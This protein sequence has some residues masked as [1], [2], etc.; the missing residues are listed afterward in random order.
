[1][2]DQTEVVDLEDEAKEIVMLKIWLYQ[3]GKESLVFTAEFHLRNGKIK[4][5][6]YQ[7]SK[8]S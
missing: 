7:G 6:K 1:M 2:H 4:S 3:R 5:G 8:S